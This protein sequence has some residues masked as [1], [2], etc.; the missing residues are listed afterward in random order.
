MNPII[1]TLVRK[2]FYVP[3]LAASM[4]VMFLRAPLAAAFIEPLEFATFAA[5]MLIANAVV[6]FGAFGYYLQQQREV[7]RLLV[8]DDQPAAARSLYDT[9]YATGLVLITG[10]AISASGLE[11]AGLEGHLVALAIVYGFSQ[12]LFLIATVDSKSRGQTTRYALQNLARSLLIILCIVYLGASFP[13]AEL[14]IGAEIAV[15][16]ACALLVLCK[17]EYFSIRT[18][19]AHAGSGRLFR[20]V[21]ARAL[22]NLIVV[23]AIGFFSLNLDRWLAA[24]M[25]PP[26]QFSLYAFAWTIMIGAISVQA[27]VSAAVFPA[28]ALRIE[29]TGVRAGFKLASITSV[30]SLV[31]MAAALPVFLVLAYWAVTEF[32]PA[33]SAASSVFAALYIA[34]LFRAADNWSP[35][36]IAG[37]F[38]QAMLRTNLAALL[39]GVTGWWLVCRWLGIPVSIHSLANLAVVLSV[40]T[41]AAFA[42]L[43]MWVTARAETPAK[44]NA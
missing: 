30:V 2:G 10:V 1:S 17:V 26:T 16:L 33:Y 24:E 43:S 3:I 14:I 11:V 6:M 4:I 18:L 9:I 8:R 15:N 13:Y 35:F 19:L 32:V 37:N 39:T 29:T 36:L 5:A 38:E 28:I 27:L 7:P 12:Q 25:L 31:F 42:A 20:H 41:F 21:R 34:G 23:S 44:P 40:G 22:I